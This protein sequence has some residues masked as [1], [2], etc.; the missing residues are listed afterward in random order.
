MFE[1]NEKSEYLLKEIEEGNVLVDENQKV[2]RIISRMDK[3]LTEARWGN[4]FVIPFEFKRSLGL[5]AE[6]E[7]LGYFVV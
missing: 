4:Y 2:A 5:K 6:L 1:K 3:A 7:N